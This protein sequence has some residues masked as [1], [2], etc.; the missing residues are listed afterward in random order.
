MKETEDLIGRYLDASPSKGFLR[1]FEQAMPAFA[2]LFAKQ[3][4]LTI[5]AKIRYPMRKP[6]Q[7]Y[8]NTFIKDKHSNLKVQQQMAKTK[9]TGIRIE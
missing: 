7:I 9:V 2:G 8:A 6:N 1:A 5:D 3:L 4:A